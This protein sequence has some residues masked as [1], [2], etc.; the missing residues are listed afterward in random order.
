VRL[1]R[2]LARR[3]K[4]R[5]VAGDKR[6]ALGARVQPAANERLVDPVRRNLKGSPL[7]APKSSGDALGPQPGVPEA[8]RDDP[9]LEHR[10]ELVGHLR[11]ATLARAQHLK[12][13]PLDLPLPAVEGRAMHA[14]RPA[15]LRRPDLLGRPEQR[16][17][18]AEQHVIVRHADSSTSSLGGEEATMSRNADGLGDL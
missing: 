2:G 12:P 6:Q 13:G 10:R 16:Q 7:R 8:E 14:H 1:G 17:A 9:L 3:L 15:R 18:L 4:R 11:A 5:A